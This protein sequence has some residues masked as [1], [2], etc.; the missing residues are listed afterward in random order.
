MRGYCISCRDWRNMFLNLEEVKALIQ[1]SKLLHIAGDESLLS[2]LPKGNWIGGTTPYFITNEGGILTKD[3]LFVNDLSDFS[4][5]KVAIY[6]N[7]IIDDILKDSYDN[8]LAF[9][10]VPFSSEVALTYAKQAPYS[11]EL[12]LKPVVGW[13]SGFDLSLGGSAKVFDGTTGQVYEDKGVALHIE[14]PEGRMAGIN[15]VNI[16]SEDE[17]GDI[18]EFSE[19]AFEVSECLI[20]G[21]NINLVDYIKDNNIDIQMPLVANNNGIF[22][23]VSIKS[24]DEDNKIVHFYAPVFADNKYCFAKD[25]TDYARAFADNIADM[26]DVKPL[27]SCNCIL[28]YLYGELEGKKTPPFEGPITFGEVAY[29]LL[30]QTLVYVEC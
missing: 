17:A 9:L 16:F 14:L 5:F 10:I 27:F 2:Q 13:V 11:S 1:E 28:N 8:G 7:N 21:N 23:N 20:N 12:L 18:I 24:I 4:N 6:D 29:Q 25:V 15:I 19:D 30:N 3:K 22:I 26:E